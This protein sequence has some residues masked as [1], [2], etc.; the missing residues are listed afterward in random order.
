MKQ[1]HLL[2]SSIV[3]AL[4]IAPTWAAVAATETASI[5]DTIE[6]PRVTK[7]VS[8]NVVTTLPGTHVRLVEHLTQ[9]G[10]VDD[11]YKLPHLQLVLQPSAK[12]KAALDALITQQH[13]PGSAN[14]QK[15]MSPDQF[16]ESFGIADS[17]I[18]A[19]TT[20]L[21]SQGFVV[22]T[23]YPN[24]TQIDFSGTVGQVRQAFKTQLARYTTVQ[25]DAHIANAS[26]ISIPTALA[27]VIKGV[28]G[29]N[30]FS[31]KPLH[32]TPAIGK[33]NTK[34]RQFE[35][36]AK[37][38]A[39]ASLAAAGIQPNAI[40]GTGVRGLVPSDMTKIYNVDAVR[41]SGLTG[42][43]VTI[44]LVEGDEMAPGDW[45]NFVAQFNLGKYGGT[46]SQIN[47]APPSGPTNCIS[48][49]VVQSSIAGQPVQDD[50][51]ETV[52]DAEWSTAMAPGAHVTVAACADYDTN[53]VDTTSNFFGGAFVASSNIVNQA[54]DRPNII[55]AS[56]G[57][58]EHDVDS[59]SKTAIDQMW[60]QADAEGISVFVASGD[61]GSNPSFN[62][63]FITGEGVDA[64]AYASSPNVTAVGG[65]D[66][67]DILDGTTAQY[68][69]AKPNA[70]YGSAL[71]YVPEIP[72]NASCGNDVAAKEAWGMSALNLCKLYLKLDVNNGF[73]VTSEAGGG[74]PSSVDSKPA[75]QSLVKGMVR[76]SARDLP[77][78]ALFAG[79]YNNYSA[80]ILCTAAYP[81][82]AGFASPVQLVQGTSLAAPMFAGIQAV[83]NQGLA[84]KGQPV[85]Q[86]NAAPTL[87]AL[88][89]D[90][91]GGPTGRAPSTLA[92]CNADNGI[93]GTGGCV[94]H[95]VTRGSISTQCLYLKDG[96]AILGAPPEPTPDCYFYGTYNNVT[97]E[98]IIPLGPADT[99]LT[100]LST[101][102]YGQATKAYAAT[103]GWSFASGLG[104]VNV[105]NLLAAWKA[106]EKAAP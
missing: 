72:W 62:G 30:D 36:A 54:S 28:V 9:T 38:G 13:T 56:Y 77:D 5:P 44:A 6:L 98:G 49:S 41:S 80:V 11:T 10:T 59:A 95:N 12:R 94:F 76:D 86:G 7:A 88:A 1:R 55:S 90:E 37:T 16:G 101:A 71:S 42:A 26:D 24:K 103:P 61:S 67:A 69:G 47:P 92:T 27:P 85:N 99:G 91:Y 20:W 87:Y 89:A 31:L 14:F 58:G 73:Y 74:G 84:K 29:L 64:N 4:A 34:S 60:A 102:T 83:I 23:V 32:T 82:T 40:Q 22:N 105:K 96:I 106:Y 104:S 53:F 51:T 75:W 52:L 18:A 57:F 79:S 2:R 63:L 33:F 8:A 19:A 43:G 45:T 35:V 66:F 21:Q 50:G 100:S 97:L 93:N 81:C 70:D 46:F 39:R 78:V 25:G 3:L 17:D 65:T 68:F 15:W 48:P